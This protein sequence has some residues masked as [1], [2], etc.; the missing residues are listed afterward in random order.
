VESIAKKKLETIK[1]TFNVSQIVNFP[2]RVANNKVT[3]I[4][5]IF[6][7]TIQFKK[8]TPCPY[9]TLINTPTKCTI[10]DRITFYSLTPST[11]TCFG[12]S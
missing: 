6:L 5:C 1:K 8:V 7:D 11:P 3:L 9:I 10:D 2:T 12:V 4:D